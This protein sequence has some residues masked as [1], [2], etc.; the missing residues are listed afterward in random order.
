MISW[1]YG[2]VVGVLVRLMRMVGFKY[3]V[4][5]SGSRAA[6]RTV[7]HD[8]I[9]RYCPSESRA[10]GRSL[11]ALCQPH[12]VRAKAGSHRIGL[13]GTS[14]DEDLQAACEEQVAHQIVGIAARHRSTH[15]AC[16]GYPG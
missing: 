13:D 3:R 9:P 1:Q 6:T 7:S 2:Q 12:S 11:S 4:G 5:L 10:Q 14:V 16:C 8:Q 15:D